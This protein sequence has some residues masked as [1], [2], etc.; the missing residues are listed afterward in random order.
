[1]LFLRSKKIKCPIEFNTRVPPMTVKF[2]MIRLV[3]AGLWSLLHFC[4]SASA[5][6]PVCPNSP[7]LF[8]LLR[9]DEDNQYLS[10]STC[11]QDYWDR[12]KCVPLGSNEERFLTVGGEVREWYE[13]FRNAS[14]GFGT[15]DENGYLLQRLTMYADIHAAPRVRFFVQLTSDIEAGRNGGR[16]R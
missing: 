12:L 11:R 8:G 15:Q 14:W 6:T 4:I 16:G 3:G 2:Q 9:Q 5:Q 1:M 7:Q 10:N 13:G